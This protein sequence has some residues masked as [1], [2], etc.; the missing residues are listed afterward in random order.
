MLALQHNNPTGG[1][2]WVHTHECLLASPTQRHVV[3]SQ[4]AA[5]ATSVCC[6]Q[7]TPHH[8]VLHPVPHISSSAGSC[9]VHSY[10][11]LTRLAR[12]TVL[13]PTPTARCLLCACLLLAGTALA[14]CVLPPQSVCVR[15][16]ILT[17]CVG[18]LSYIYHSFHRPP[19]GACLTANLCTPRVE[20]AQIRHYSACIHDHT[21]AW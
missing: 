10:E 9:C 21:R 18:L 13:L 20:I 3:G 14:V 12:R 7:H 16:T 2:P 6:L 15:M 8:P 1:L 11:N 17:V 5:T 19:H 4:L